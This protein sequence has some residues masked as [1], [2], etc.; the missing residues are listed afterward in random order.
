MSFE[1]ALLGLPALGIAGLVMV[2]SRDWLLDKFVFKDDGHGRHVMD[3]YDARREQGVSYQASSDEL[4]VREI[5]ARL[6]REASD[7]VRADPKNWL[8]HLVK[9]KADS[10]ANMKEIDPKLCPLL[11]Q[12]IDGLDYGNI[13][14]PHEAKLVDRQNGSERHN[15]TEDMRAALRIVK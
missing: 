3:F 9:A 15:P 7:A 2:K 12:M 8:A 10:F 13:L 5:F 11:G 6:R 14:Y 1:I 4:K